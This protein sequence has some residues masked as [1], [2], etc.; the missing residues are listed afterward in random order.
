MDNVLDFF[1][2]YWRNLWFFFI[3]K[4]IDYSY[5]I[6]AAIQKIIM[7]VFIIFFIT[8]VLSIG[9]EPL[10]HQYKIQEMF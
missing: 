5:V 2:S 9:S 4:L 7:E 3:G 6:N 8:Q 1:K 10:P